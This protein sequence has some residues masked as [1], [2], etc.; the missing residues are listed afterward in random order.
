MAIRSSA[1]DEEVTCHRVDVDPGFVLRSVSPGQR[2]GAGL[3]DNLQV[4][5]SVTA[6]ADPKIGV[7]VRVMIPPGHQQDFS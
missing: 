5:M 3:N 1:P 2:R 6:Q 4:P 7:W